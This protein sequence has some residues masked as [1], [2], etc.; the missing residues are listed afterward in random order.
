L[1]SGKNPIIFTL[2]GTQRKGEVIVKIR[3]FIWE[4][5]SGPFVSWSGHAEYPSTF[6]QELNDQCGRIIFFAALIATF[7]WLPYIPI[8][9]QLYPGEPLIVALR[10]GLSL[11]GLTV[12][13]LQGFKRL[14]CYNLLFLILIGAYLEI[15]TGLITGLTKA[16]SAYLGGYLIVLT[17][18]ALVPIPRRE[19]WSILAASLLVF[20]TAGFAKGM[21]FDS[22]RSRYNLNDILV[23]VLVVAFFIYLLDRLRFN[24]WE[25][26]KKIGRQNEDLKA[27]KAKIDEL[28][29][30]IRLSEAR[31]RQLFDQSPVGIFL[32]TAEGKMLTANRA[33]LD[34]LK[35]ESI[36]A[37]NAAGLPNLYVDLNAR[38]TLWEKVKSGPV[39]GYETVFRRAD[40]ELISVSIGSY[41]V[42][43][44]AGNASFREGTIEDITERKRAEEALRESKDRLRTIIEGTQALLIRD[45]KSVV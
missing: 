3:Q 36:D 4:R 30:G 17:V 28:L 38:A 11:V 21:H 39:S 18:L 25:K 31:Y 13:V 27:D 29:Q 23:T 40:G 33:T 44:E 8:D 7:A 34:L 19:A 32:T 2:V 26:S 10:I 37:V 43:D 41:L 14:H 20:F 42:Y 1:T 24:S 22:V 6:Q 45:R 12:L 16:D 35:F 15:A 5:L 9:R